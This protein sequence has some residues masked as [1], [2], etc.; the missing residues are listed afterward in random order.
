[1]E[2]GV[3]S[4]LY[5]SIT[6]NYFLSLQKTSFWAKGSMNE[7]FEKVVQGESFVNKLYA[8]VFQKN[9]CFSKIAFEWVAMGTCV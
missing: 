6:R 7:L 8:C 3:Y 5:F 2:S 1:M 9:E 4:K